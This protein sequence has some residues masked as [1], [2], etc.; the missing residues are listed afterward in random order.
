MEVS[1]THFFGITI[2]PNIIS[3]IYVLKSDEITGKRV[4]F[5]L[6]SLCPLFILDKIYFVF[7]TFNAIV[8]LGIQMWS[9]KVFLSDLVLLN[10]FISAF[11]CSDAITSRTAI[12][13]S[14]NVTKKPLFVFM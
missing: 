5:R 11:P 14:S 12:V 4:V 8:A 3:I 9:A 2:M 1:N 7:S 6:S 10:T 13:Q